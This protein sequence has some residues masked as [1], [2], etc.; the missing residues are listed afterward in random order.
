MRDAAAVERGRVERRPARQHHEQRALAQPIGQ[1]R[2]GF[3][4]R[5]VGPLQVLEHEHQRPVREA[6]LEH[7]AQ[8]HRDLALE[9]LGLDLARSFDRLQAEDVADGRHDQLD[10][11][12]V[13]TDGAHALLDLCTRQLQRIGG[14]DAVALDEEARREAVGP[15]AD[16]RGGDAAHSRLLEAGGATQPLEHLVD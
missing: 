16:R 3:D 9:P 5:R 15:R 14:A 13:S 1:R 4:R 8:R 11:G 2:D 7:R 6:A 10:L 12:V